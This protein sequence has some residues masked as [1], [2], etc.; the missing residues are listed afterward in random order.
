MKKVSVVIPAYRAE[1]TIA[2]AVMSALDQGDRIGK[3]IVVVDGILDETPTVLSNIEDDRLKVIVLPENKGAQ[4]AR[5]T[6]LEKV[7]DDYVIFLDSDDYFEGNLIDGMAKLM[8]QRDVDLCIAPN[9]SIDK[10]KNKKYFKVS[11]DIES[12]DFLVGRVLSTM[13]VGI[14]CL[15]WRKEFVKNIGGWDESVIRNQDGELVIRAL[16]FGATLC[17]S[18]IGAG[19]SV[20]Y[21]GDRV[22]RK[23][24]IESFVSQEA[25]YER[26]RGYLQSEKLSS[27][28]KEELLAALN[29]FCVNICIG[30]SEAGFIGSEY[31][32]WRQRINWKLI[33]Y[34]FLPKVKSIQAFV[35]FIFGKKTNIVKGIVRHFF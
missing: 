25:I 5:N 16:T 11:D 26:V 18:D 15:L 4:V 20:Q 28:E 3:V 21:D 31:S 9:C 1:K 23:R 19:C 22:S 13:A 17:V 8:D 12:F 7:N 35:F 30:M 14:Q 32:V 6:G 27:S 2:K 33:H 34:C 10:D 24:N 29:W